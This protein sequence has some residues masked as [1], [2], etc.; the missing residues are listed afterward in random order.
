MFTEPKIK[1]FQ[2]DVVG[3]A[4]SGHHQLE[5]TVSDEVS[6]SS[7]DLEVHVQVG[8]IVLDNAPL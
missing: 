1:R 5:V 7:L 2:V 6:T 4:P 3:F 8:N